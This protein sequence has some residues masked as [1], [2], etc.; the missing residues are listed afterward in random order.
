MKIYQ[1]IKTAVAGRFD[2]NTKVCSAAFYQKFSKEY[3]ATVLKETFGNNIIIE[4]YN[5]NNPI[6]SNK[7]INKNWYK[8]SQFYNYK[9]D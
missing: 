6:F 4:F 8:F 3:V 7:N 1:I 9:E 5:Y 2:P